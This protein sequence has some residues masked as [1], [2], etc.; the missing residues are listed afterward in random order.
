M[1]QDFSIFVEF[2]LK[3]SIIRVVISIS[4]ISK[5]IISNVAILLK[6]SVII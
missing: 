2:N 3:K 4:I 5:S 1:C 6:N